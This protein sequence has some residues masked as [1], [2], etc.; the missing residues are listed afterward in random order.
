MSIFRI[1]LGIKTIYLVKTAVFKLGR[2][3]FLARTSLVIRDQSPFKLYET[4][5]QDIFEPSVWQ[6]SYIPM[7][8]QRGLVWNLLY[9]RG[10]SNNTWHSKGRGSTKMSHV[11]FSSI[12]KLNFTVKSNISIKWK[13]SCPMEGGL[14]LSKK[15]SR[16]I[17]MA[18]MK[19]NNHKCTNRL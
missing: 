11:I 12:K 5:L 10:L 6:N 16:I 18:P 19:K 1:W 7:P 2:R 15:V 8:M 17:Q 14:K 3:P 13:L 9:I 4:V